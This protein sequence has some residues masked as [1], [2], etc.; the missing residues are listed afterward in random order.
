MIDPFLQVQSTVRV[1]LS[2]NTVRVDQQQQGFWLF[3]QALVFGLEFSDKGMI[4]LQKVS[5]P[6]VY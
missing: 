3:H 2:E 5:K 1:N 6:Y 4:P